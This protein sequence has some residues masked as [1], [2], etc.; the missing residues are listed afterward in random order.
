R[1]KLDLK[2][3][4]LANFVLIAK[5]DEAILDDEQEKRRA[6]RFVGRFVVDEQQI[7]FQHSPSDTPLEILDCKWLSNA[8]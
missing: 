5:F 4:I 8:R 3:E 1:L 2:R 6:V 7:R